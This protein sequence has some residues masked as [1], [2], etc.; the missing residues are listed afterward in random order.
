MKVI[1]TDRRM[2]AKV[3]LMQPPL[4]CR[5]FDV[6]GE[7]VGRE[8]GALL[9]GTKYA[10]ERGRKSVQKHFVATRE[11]EFSL[12]Q[13]VARSAQMLRGRIQ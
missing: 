6:A 8:G 5:E 2:K 11:I 9:I 10:C 1:T 4:D 7:G 13:I 3:T 12:Y